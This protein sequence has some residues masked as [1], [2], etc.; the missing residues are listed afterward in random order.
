M[1][2]RHQG[3][4]SRGLG[5]S[6]AKGCSAS[7]KDRLYRKGSLRGKKVISQLCDG[8]T[9]RSK[10]SCS[11]CLLSEEDNQT[12]PATGTGTIRDGECGGKGPSLM[13]GLLTVRQHK[14]HSVRRVRTLVETGYSLADT[15]E[16]SGFASSMKS[17]SKST[18]I[19]A[20][21]RR[22]DCNVL[23]I[24]IYSCLQTVKLHRSHWL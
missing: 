17:S 6:S 16:S 18:A 23:P 10:G 22:Q 21:L 24:I 13:G 12:A 4:P 14:Q 7:P 20:V 8:L 1:C 11:L 5:T 2:H 9:V 3:C 15:F 19:R